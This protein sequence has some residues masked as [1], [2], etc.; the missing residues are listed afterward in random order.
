MENQYNTINL[1]G[2]TGVI[3]TPNAEVINNGFVVSLGH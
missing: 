2:A 3:N 1:Q